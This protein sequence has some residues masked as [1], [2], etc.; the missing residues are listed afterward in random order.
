MTRQNQGHWWDQ[1][2]QEFQSM[3]FLTGEEY[4]DKGS[5]KWLGGR[6][7]YKII[8]LHKKEKITGKKYVLIKFKVKPHHL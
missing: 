5:K 6:G 3:Y 1:R 4:E 7:G 8:P 2:Y